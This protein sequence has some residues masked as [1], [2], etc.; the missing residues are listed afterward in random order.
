[1][2][3]SSNGNIFRVTD[4]AVTHPRWPA[5]SPDK[6][7]W[8]GALMISLI[9]DCTKG[10]S[11]HRDAGDL[12]CRRTYYDVTVMRDDENVDYGDVSVSLFSFAMPHNRHGVSNTS[13]SSVWICPSYKVR[14]R[15]SSKLL[16]LCEGNLP[17]MDTTGLLWGD[18]WWSSRTRGQ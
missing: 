13:N 11:N 3:T 1:M 5:N 8:R 14:K 15:Q 9:C 7:Q 2:M 12:R 10:R 4:P 18:H 16:A 17:M 6:G